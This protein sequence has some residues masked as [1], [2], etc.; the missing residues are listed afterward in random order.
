MSALEDARAHVAKAQ[1]FLEAARFN[2]DLKLYSA[3]TSDA[4]VAGINA[5]DATCLRLTGV[6]RKSDNHVAA[7]AELKAAGPAGAGLAPTLARLIK[8][9]ARAQYQSAAVSAPDAANAVRWASKL[10]EGAEEVV[11]GR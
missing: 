9:K 4:V 10:V 5:K 11:K 8:M 7:I 1:E 6:T 2:L 3:A